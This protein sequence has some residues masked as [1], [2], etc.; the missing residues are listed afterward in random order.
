MKKITMAISMAAILLVPIHAQEKSGT[1]EPASYEFW[2]NANFQLSAWGAFN[3][4]TKSTFSKAVDSTLS[5]SGTYYSPSFG[6]IGWYGNS[7]TQVGFSAGYMQIYTNTATYFGQEQTERLTY[8]PMELLARYYF[9]K[10]LWAGAGFGYSVGLL[11]ADNGSA[12]TKILLSPIASLRAGYDY[13]ITREFSL[14][15]FVNFAYSFATVNQPM[16]QASAADY[17]ANSFNIMPGIAANYTF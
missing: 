6:A 1:S 7:R 3:Y 8:I 13:Q 16:G 11:K 14:S 17:S 4:S 10:G 5:N 12:T 15:G 9:I 2:K